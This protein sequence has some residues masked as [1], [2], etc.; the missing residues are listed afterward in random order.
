MKQAIS[1]FKSGA[2][3]YQK[4]MSDSVIVYLNVNHIIKERKYYGKY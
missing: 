1:R 2:M 4:F 3:Q